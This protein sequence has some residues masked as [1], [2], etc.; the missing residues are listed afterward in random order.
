MD[1]EWVDVFP[2]EH[3][4][5]PA[6]YVSLLERIIFASFSVK[7]RNI[8]QS[9]PKCLVENSGILNASLSFSSVFY[10]QPFHY[11]VARDCQDGLVGWWRGR[12]SLPLFQPG[13]RR[14]EMEEISGSH[15]STPQGAKRRM[16]EPSS[17]SIPGWRDIL[18]GCFNFNIFCCFIFI[19][20]LIWGNGINHLTDA[21]LFFRVGST[22]NLALCTSLGWGN[23]NL[24]LDFATI[25]YYRSP[26]GR[27]HGHV[28]LPDSLDVDPGSPS[29][30]NFAQW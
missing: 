2:I 15:W 27:F 17:L 10:N 11:C 23:L 1:T 19:P 18:G 4:D 7:T 20:P 24:N 16:L 29:R 9:T 25:I 8:F 6:S 30:P 26:P 5:F 22:T 21:H 13:D 3:G 28:R 14:E 12:L